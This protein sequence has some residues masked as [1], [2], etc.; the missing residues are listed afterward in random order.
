LFGEVILAADSDP[1]GVGQNLDGRLC[2]VRLYYS[3]FDQSEVEVLSNTMA[4]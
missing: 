2:E 1:S 4:R 3:A